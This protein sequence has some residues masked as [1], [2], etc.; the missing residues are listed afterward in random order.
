MSEDHITISLGLPEVRVLSY[1]DTGEEHRIRAEKVRCVVFC[2]QCGIRHVETTGEERWRTIQDLP[3]S[4]RPVWIELR[5]RRFLC[6]RGHRFWERFD[7]VALKQRQTARF[8]QWLL[9]QLKGSSIAEAVRRT[10]VGYRVLEWLMLKIGTACAKA[11]RPWP[12]VLGIDE[13]ASRKGR[14]YDTVVVD[15]KGPTIFE[16]GEGKSA[17]SLSSLWDR[18]PG[19]K[20]I[21]AA[22][23]DMSRGFLAGLKT[24]GHRITIA[25]DRFH[26]EKH[27]LA[28]V[29]EVRRRI[30]RSVPASQRGRVKE[31]GSLL[32]IPRQKLSPEELALCNLL[33]EDYPEIA[34]ALSLAEQVNRWYDHCQSVEEARKE[35][36][37]WFSH[38]ESSG[39][40]EMI[41]ATKALKEWFEYILNYFVLFLTNGPTEGLNTKIKL[42]LRVAF[43]VPSFERR[44][45][46]LLFQCGGAPYSQNC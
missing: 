19:K 9:R 37:W 14:H 41:Q 38:V 43:G 46:R 21:R 12:K 11:D 28:A 33:L 24:L 15:L 10:G 31:L 42:I 13:Y 5:Q 1:E 16:V 34:R 45:A 40:E 26:V 32:R 7:T 30:Q 3:I 44:R 25:I 17:E 39:I 2:P 6:N 23:I 35:L 27:V 18:H 22:V 29:D 8:Q 20:R 36:V 4:G